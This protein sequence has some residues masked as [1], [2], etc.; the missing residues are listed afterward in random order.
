MH[1]LMRS[2]RRF[3]RFVRIHKSAILIYVVGGCFAFGGLLMLW[4]AT[5]NIPD[6]QTLETRRV[7]QSLK[8]YDRTGETLLYDLNPNVRRTLVPLSQISPL[9]QNATTAIED[10][11][12]Y[13]HAGFKST[14][15][16]SASIANLTSFGYAQGG[17]TIT[18][19][20]VKLT[21]LSGNKTI[22]RKFEEIILALKLE[23]VA[24]KQQILELYLNTVPYGGAIYGVEEASQD[25]FGKSAQDVTLPEAAYLAA[26]LPA[27]TYYSPWGNHKAALDQRKNLVLEKMFEHGYISAQERDAAK[28]AQVEFAGKHRAAIAA[29]HFVFYVQQL[30]E[31]K[32]GP[33]VLETAGWRVITTLDAD[34]QVKAEETVHEYALSN[35][36]NFNASNMGAVALNPQTGE[37]LAMV[38]SRDYFDTAIP[39][40]YNIAL[41]ERQPGSTF[42]PFAYAK[43]F[44]KGYTPNTV[45]FDLPTQFSTNCSP[46]DTRT[47]DTGADAAAGC[48]APVNYDGKYRGPITMRNA[49]AQSINIPSIQVLYLAGISDTLELA[50]SMGLST[51]GDAS[52]YGLTLVLGGGEVTLL[53]MASAYGA[54]AANG[55]HYEPSAI[56]KIEDAQGT[57][58][59]D[60]TQPKPATQVL[61]PKVASQM[62]EVLSDAVARG[63]LGTGDIFNF[64]GQ[65]VA[66]K[67]GTTNNYRDAWTIGYTPNIVVGMWAGNNDNTP[68]EKRVSGLIVGPA[69][70]E[71]MRYA[72]TKAPPAS[73]TRVDGGYTSSKPILNGIWQGGDYSGGGV[74]C[75]PHSILYWVD[76][77]NPTGPSPRGGSDDPQLRYWEYPVQLWAASSGCAP[78][79]VVPIGGGSYQQP[80]PVVPQTVQP[81]FNPGGGAI[82]PQ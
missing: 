42:K 32:Y 36:E 27:P 3:A 57:I 33:D 63:P 38:G 8:I 53:E 55:V 20:A 79:S 58:I 46:Y 40:A 19:Q 60:H 7:E 28:E 21:M 5:L 10:S 14:S 80:Q 68:M 49:I 44:E 45:L 54:F 77:N 82:I 4:A 22:T 51:L 29:P 78:G 81:V 73:F 23:R 66:V 15:F 25:F 70:S 26:V 43:A 9:G 17:S 65:D 24:N 13:L 71:V 2:L 31:G 56:L 30:L 61:D 12:F 41:A 75:N 69:W 37:I 48:Y 39:G 1:D 18:Q 67:T 11:G 64:G 47:T 76:K 59:E 34:L 74:V 52:R 72:L 6:L 62:N 35:T 50:K 16:I